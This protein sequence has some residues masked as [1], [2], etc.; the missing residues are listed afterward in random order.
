MSTVATE[1]PGPH[2]LTERELVALAQG[3]GTGRAIRTL[4]AARRSRTML[5]IHFVVQSTA[6]P[7]TRALYQT[8]R[9]VQKIAPAAVTKV[10][11]HPSVGAWAT[12]TA[13]GINRG[14]PADP[15]ALARVILAAAARGGVKVPV[16]TPACEEVFLPS[17]G[18]AIP[19]PAT[20]EIH[21]PHTWWEEGPGWHPT[22]R[23]DVNCDGLQASFLLDRWG[24]GELPNDLDVAEDPDVRQWRDRITEGWDLLVRHHRG[25]AE[26]LATVVTTLT[27]LRDTGDGLRSATADDA[28]GCLF[29]SLPPDAATAAVTLTHELQHTKLIALMDLFSMV[30]P[31]E[32]KRFYAP[33]RDDPRPAA[34][35]LHGIFAFSGVAGFW[36]RQ[37]TLEPVT[38]QE[39]H[40]N[41]EFARWR[42]GA[43]DAAHTLL[44]SDCLTNIGRTFVSA[45]AD[46]LDQWHTEPVPEPARAI[47]A[48]LAE[49]HH[50]RWRDAHQ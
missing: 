26:E 47:A 31:V 24:P 34:G 19:H 7:R 13:A 32:R 9:H 50:S 49:E 36:R 4:A 27:P 30:D 41:V 38:E 6:D 37:R 40:A 39:L 10:L 3:A 45:I 8:L 33:W 2:R 44:N 5:L 25:V 29:L 20:G 17:L 42:A 46:L 35:L 21:V 28:F 16:P 15:A 14:E 11:D 48:Q 18:T 12:R 1:I 43:L 23:I 22:P